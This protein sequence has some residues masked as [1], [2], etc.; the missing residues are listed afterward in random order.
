[1][2]TNDLCPAK[3]ADIVFA[4]QRLGQ[5]S[6]AQKIPYY[7]FADFYRTQAKLIELGF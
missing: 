2:S 5:L 4:R 1:M 3:E 7:Q 6:M